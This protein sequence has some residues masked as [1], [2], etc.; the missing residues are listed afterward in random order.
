M[1]IV[2]IKELDKK[3]FDVLVSHSRSPHV[4]MYATEISWFSNEDETVLG[5]I[6][7]D[8]IDGDFSAIVL[9][10]DEIQRYRAFDLSVSFPSYDEALVW[11]TGTI[12]WNTGLE[13]K[14]FL[15]HDEDRPKLDLFKPIVELEKQHPSFAKLNSES[16]F[17][18][19][20]S[21]INELM[22]HFIDVDGNYIEQFQSTGFDSRI[23]ELYLFSFLNEEKF[24][25]D[26]KHHSPDFIALKGRET[27]AI[28]AVIVGR[29]QDNPPSYLNL[30]QKLKS[31][32]AIREELK[33]SMPIKYGSPLYSKL[34][35]KYWELPHVKEK[36]L[37]LAIADFH[38]DASMMWSGSALD[39]YL[40][41]MEYEHH[42]DEN[43]HL[44]VKGKK[45]KS[46]RVGEKEIPSGFF[47]QP[48][49]ENISGVLF[50]S[51]GTISKFNRMGRQAGYGNKNILM[52]RKG[53]C[54]DHDPNA[55]VPKLFQYI[56][57]ESSNETWGEGVSIFHNPNAKYPL[58]I[59]LFPNVAHHFL[60]NDERRSYI[61]DFH[62]ISSLT[63]SYKVQE[64]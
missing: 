53:A 51:S 12:K 4:E 37:L 38:D 55:S 59:E 43:G 19:A 52:V 27:I 18:P 26:R 8:N 44:V 57:S 46:H 11:V 42:Y 10:R 31:E 30:F 54:H 24:V 16:S 29:R 48:D 34:K 45:I 63:I 47:F 6:L 58:D 14:V 61:P 9:G 25:L 1:N 5:L 33:D 49:V 2:N 39:T 36:P 40:Y 20:K 60:I 22:P 62:S 28:E 13:K 7:L 21:I 56:V 23:W 35:K 50:S 64:E 41:G 17:I 3:R 32:E 15:Q